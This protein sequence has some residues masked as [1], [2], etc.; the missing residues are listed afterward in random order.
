MSLIQTEQS[1]PTEV[2]SKRTKQLKEILDITHEMLGSAREGEWT[3]VIEQE[4]QR[5]KVMHEF[6]SKKV[7]VREAEIVAAGIRQI[8][9][10]DKQ[11]M[12]LGKNRMLHLS[13]QVTGVRKGQK[14]QKA[15]AACAR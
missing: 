10:I 12:E 4:A 5:Q 15:Y 3:T 1:S 7:S 11:V 2:E 9:D 13:G 8:L 6:F 14:A